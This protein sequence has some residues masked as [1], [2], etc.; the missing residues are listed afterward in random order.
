MRIGRYRHIY[1][2]NLDE[3]NGKK[4]VVCHYKPGKASVR[5][6]FNK[7]YELVLYDIRRVIFK[8]K[9]FLK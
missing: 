9:L 4:Y 7:W 5:W 8:I 1:K 3:N 2:N 6:F